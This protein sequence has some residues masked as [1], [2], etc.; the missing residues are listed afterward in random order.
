MRGRVDNC[1]FYRCPHPSPHCVRNWSGDAIKQTGHSSQH[2]IVR[3]A[4]PIRARLWCGT[5]ARLS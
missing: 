4:C 3:A 2:Q 1:L 5:P